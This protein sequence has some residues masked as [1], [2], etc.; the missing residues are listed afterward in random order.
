MELYYFSAFAKKAYRIDPGFEVLYEEH[1]FRRYQSGQRALFSGSH[2]ITVLQYAYVYMWPI[3][4]FCG[5][6]G[7]T[8]TFGNSVPRTKRRAQD[9]GRVA[10]CTFCR[11]CHRRAPRPHT[12]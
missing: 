3:L 2:I 7:P 6:S 10:R 8:G 11:T 5:R 1:D 9:R 4:H 12:R